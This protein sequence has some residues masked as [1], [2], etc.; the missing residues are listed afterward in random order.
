MLEIINNLQ[1]FFENCY[2][3]IGIRE[4]SR[5]MNISPPTAS[6]LLKNYEKEKLLTKERDRNYILF[7]ANRESKYFI[8]LSRIYWQKRLDRITKL[9]EQALPDAVVLFGSLSK[10]E[11]K[12]DSDID[13]AIFAADKIDF[14]KTEDGREIQIFW[15]RSFAEIKNKHLK[16]NIINGHMLSGRLEI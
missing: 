6:S 12:P 1:P 5:Y 15:F 11:V 10:A 8:M 2:I 7:T 3:R 9:V 14:K 13:I 16:N 4:Y